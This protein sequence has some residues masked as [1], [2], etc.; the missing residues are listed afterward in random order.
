[1]L[2]IEREKSSTTTDSN[3][4]RISTLGPGYQ[5]HKVCAQSPGD[6]LVERFRSFCGGYRPFLG[7]LGRYLADNWQEMLDHDRYNNDQH[8][9][10]RLHPWGVQRMAHKDGGL[11]P[12][13]GTEF[14][15]MGYRH[16]WQEPGWPRV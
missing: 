15:S 14:Q 4:G 12:R 10:A 3:L 2:D 8:I 6:N 9:H 13:S 5:L 7:G 16:Q 11:S 1:M